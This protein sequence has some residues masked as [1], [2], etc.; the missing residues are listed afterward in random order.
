MR[1]CFGNKKE[2]N[3]NS[4]ICKVCEDKVGCK[5]QIE[6]LKNNKND[7]MVSQV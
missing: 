3:P 2:F 7:R 6:L 4:L 1:E 5:K